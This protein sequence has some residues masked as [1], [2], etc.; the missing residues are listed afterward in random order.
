MQNFEGQL[1][2]EILEDE[3]DMMD[4]SPQISPEHHSFDRYFLND[5]T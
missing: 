3:I 1:D 5:Q 4:M 2:C